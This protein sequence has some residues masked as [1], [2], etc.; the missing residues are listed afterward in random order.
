MD[1][2]NLNEKQLEAVKSIG[3]PNL[4]FAGAGSGKTRVLTYKIAY[5]IQEV[6]LSPDR[7]LAVTF[8]N[9]AAQEM[10]SRVQ[11]LLDFDISSI[12]IG[13]FHSISA[14]LLRKE[15]HN[16][17]IS[18]SFIIYD[19]PDSIS[20]IKDSIK[21]LGLDIKQFEPKT[22]KNHISQL[23]NDLISY[24]QAE[25]LA[26]DFLSKKVAEVYKI[27]QTQ[28]TNNSA[29]DF[30]DLL[31]KPLELFKNFPN[32]L[33][34]YQKKYSYI[35]VD[36]YQDTNKPQF[37][38]IH[39]LAVH[40]RDICVVGDDDQ[41]IYGWRGADISNILNFSDA[42]GESKIFKLEQNYRSTQNILDAAYF[43]ISKNSKRADKRIWT[44][45]KIGDPIC[46][47]ENLNDSMEADK[48]LNLISQNTSSGEYDFS[49]FVILYRTNAQ[50]RIIEDKLRRQGIPYHIIGGVK[51]YERKEIKDMLAYLK[52]ISNPSDNVSLLRILNFP[53]R[54]IGKT[55]IDK[56]INSSK[57]N[58][59]SVF[60]ALEYIEKIEIGQSQKKTIKIFIDKIKNFK[61]KINTYNIV[62]L[63]ND[64]IE[65]FKIKEHYDKQNTSDS[66]ERW[67]NI[68]EL[69]NG[70]IDYDTEKQD[71]KLVTFL[72]EVSLLTDIDKWNDEVKQV[73]LMTIHSSKGLEFPI[74]FIA[75][76]EEGLFPISQYLDQNDELE[77]ERRLFYVGAT[78]AMDKLYLTYSKLRRRFGA[79]VMP[80]TVSRFI[81]ELPEKNI[82]YI[83]PKSDFGFS[84]KAIL[85]DVTYK[86]GQLVHHSL[87]GKGKI[88]DVEGE[89]V[90]SKISVIFHGNV[91]KKLIAKYANLK[92]VYE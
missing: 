40:H 83:K 76:L 22:F 36:E 29:L 82:E 7:I 89:G 33:E 5:L 9:K 79:E 84:S 81:N 2:S 70:M 34:K 49:D 26:N 75:G 68:E 61:N 30:D 52:V 19:Q 8:T 1:L 87:F 55:S 41:S 27:Y 67:Q 63:I 46:I 43:V 51:F 38:F 80:M 64:V 48:I 54:G 14:Q 50:S 10:K 45:N 28:L 44:D 32:I 20:V 71:A 92:I 13:T 24:D 18:N 25:T 73:T 78:R 90:Q 23:K 60:E 53:A 47:I 58:K 91:R 21:D 56:I 85:K 12:S 37:E 42:F 31:L 35:L 6:G 65:I 15:I 4:I 11:K 88:I 57:D 77:E 16:L 59:T 39:S 17:G 86:K 66:N 74:V 3:Q 62:D 72:E 69:V